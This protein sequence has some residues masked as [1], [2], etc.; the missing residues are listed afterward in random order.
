MLKY[1][2]LNE[3]VARYKHLPEQGTD[4]WKLL[5]KDFIGGSEIASVLKQNKSK[6]TN[7]LIMGKLG[8]DE[9]RGNVVTHWGNVFE[10][11]IRLHCEELFTCSIRETGSIPYEDGHLSY[12]P[13][14]LAVVSTNSFVNVFGN[15]TPGLNPK[16]PAHLTLFEFKCPHSRIASTEIPIHYL[17]QVNIGMNII[18]IMETAIFVQ[19]T[20]RR[21]TFDS[22]MYNATHNKCGHYIPYTITDPP[23]ECGFM[24]IYGKEDDDYTELIRDI[25][26]LGEARDVLID[27]DHSV[28]DLGSIYSKDVLEEVL[29]KCVSKTLN[30]D[31]CFRHTYAKRTFKSDGYVQDM[32]NASLQFQAMRVLKDQTKKHKNIICIMPFKMLTLHLTQVSKNKNYITE[33]DAHAKAGAVLKCIENHRGMLDKNVVQKSVRSCKL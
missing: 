24:T 19:A 8:F 16:E 13:D 30:V 15:L 29:G 14:G 27:N 12:S 20:Y 28:F 26:E 10:E 9:F 22:L 17:P 7:K 4:E 23:I 33:T 3:F 32:H 31:Y 1:K 11:L 2:S 21:C 5:R 6:S 18:D 25:E